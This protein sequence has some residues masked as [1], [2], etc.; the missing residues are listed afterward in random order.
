MTVHDTQLAEFWEEFYFD[1]ER[2]SA[3]PNGIL[4]EEVASLHPGRALDLGCGQGGDAIWLAECGW[5]VTAV[6]ISGN[7]LAR[8]AEHA[9]AAGVAGRI[10]WERHDLGASFPS[11]EFD[12]VSA[13]YLHSPISIP[14]DRILRAAAGA[15]APGGTLLIIGHAGP[16]SWA[17]PMHGVDFP[18]PAEV[19]DELALPIDAWTIAR[20]EGLSRNV[21]DPDGRPGTRPDNVVTLRRCEPG[22]G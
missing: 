19:I 5:Q 18:T 6:D 20:C 9:V 1:R 12:L 15:V 11:G 8:S 3:N 4:V 21:V 2:W 13:S 22:G 17:G 7:A 16:P 14:R 10:H